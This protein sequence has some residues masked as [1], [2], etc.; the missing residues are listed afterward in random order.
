VITPS[1]TPQNERDAL[2]D[3][4]QA[5]DDTGR[6]DHAGDVDLRNNG[7]GRVLGWG[8]TPTVRELGWW[9]H[10]PDGGSAQAQDVRLAIRQRVMQEID[11]LLCV[12]T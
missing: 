12:L 3:Q 6:F 9:E 1:R 7:G 5:G 8:V 2:L 10:P 11:P 4:I